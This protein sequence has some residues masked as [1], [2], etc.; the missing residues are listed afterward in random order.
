MGESMGILKVARMGHPILREV[1]A[2]L[3]AEEIASPAFQDF[4]DS[5]IATMHEYDGI[6]STRPGRHPDPRAF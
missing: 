4:V 6:G 1:A 2:E 5:M 3:D